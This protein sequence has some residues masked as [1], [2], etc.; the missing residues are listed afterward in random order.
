[1]TIADDLRARGDVVFAFTAALESELGA[2]A[3]LTIG[4]ARASVADVMAD[5]QVRVIAMHFGAGEDE[6]TLAFVAAA[7]FAETLESAAS[8]E[9]LLTSVTP[10]IEAAVQALAG[11]D[12]E[13]EPDAPAEATLAVV[14][15][16]FGADDVVA[17]PL[18]VASDVVGCLAVA[19]GGGA[20]VDAATARPTTS[21][22][23]AVAAINEAIPAAGGSASVLADVEMGV[24]AELGRCNM[25]VRELLSLTAGAVIDLD[26]TAGA[27]VDV[28]VNGTLIARGEVVVVD[29]EFGIRI[30]EIVGH[31]SPAR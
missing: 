23:A 24:T 11:F 17:Y 3:L 12:I 1:V 8:D 13:V 18:L 15:H 6:G 20:S 22:Q 14:T 31:G 28:L 19:V 10:A 25:T 21:T 9:L 29:E 7:H 4:V 2:D 26:R 16:A 5:D 27:L 30:A